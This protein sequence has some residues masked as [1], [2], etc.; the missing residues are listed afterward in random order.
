[1][2]NHV[3]VGAGP[4]GSSVA[5][6]LADAG[7]NVRIVTRSGSG[8]EHPL[9][10]RI[11]ADAGDARRLTELT[12]DA[13]VLYNCANPPYT[14]W[15][16]LWPPLSAAMITAAREN[17]AVLAITGN[18]YVYGPQPGGRMSEHT[19]LAATGRKGRVRIAMW[20]DALAAG[21]RT[22]EARGSDYVGAGATGVVS[23]VLAPAMAKGRTAWMPGD[24]DAPHTWTYVGDMARTLVALARDQRAW[25]R[26]WHV[27]STP[28]ISVRE[29]ASR[30][31]ALSGTPAVRIRRLPRPAMRTAG[32]VIPMAR[33]LA[34]MD[35]QFYGPFLLDSTETEQTFGLRATAL[36]IALKEE[37]AYAGLTH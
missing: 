28:A 31:T 9:I 13:E 16:Q 2:S 34:E 11:A 18:L 27:P 5:R 25:G 12:R 23:A 36:D 15:P 8:P 3:I 19:P 30:Y 1:M 17:D 10:E 29:L 21:I 4:V 6:L 7:E 26:A 35:Y 24:P 33:E 14:K 37:A 20:Q 22:L 32:L